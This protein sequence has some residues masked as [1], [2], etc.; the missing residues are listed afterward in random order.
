MVDS[1][2]SSPVKPPSPPKI[3]SHVEDDLMLSESSSDGEVFSDPEPAKTES[4][5]KSPTKAKLL[6]P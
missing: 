4:L 6:A 2:M 3:F 1:P 5:A